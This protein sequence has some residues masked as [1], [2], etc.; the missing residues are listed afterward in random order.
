MKRLMD[1]IAGRCGYVPREQHV[2]LRAEFQCAVGSYQRMF[3]KYCVLRRAL[4]AIIAQDTPNS[5]ATVKRM[6]KLASDG[7]G[8]A[9]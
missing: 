3:G 4:Q 1:W 6:V 2:N 7:L 8:G 9:A 5:N